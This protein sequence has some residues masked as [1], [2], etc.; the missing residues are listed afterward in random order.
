LINT[1]TNLTSKMDL[2]KLEN[3]SQQKNDSKFIRILKR[4][5]K[6]LIIYILLLISLIQLII[7]IFEKI[8]DKYLNI[9]L[10]KLT[11]KND[12][13]LKPPKSVN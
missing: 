8:D 9:I 10:E 12:T 2:V 13:F 1:S 3:F 6:C 5:F 11:L 7:L 4:K